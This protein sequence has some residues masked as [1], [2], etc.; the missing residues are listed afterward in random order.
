MSN[1]VQFNEADFQAQLQ[2]IRGGSL[3]CDLGALQMLGNDDNSDS[4]SGSELSRSLSPP[5][6]R[7]GRAVSVSSEPRGTANNFEREL[8]EAIQSLPDKTIG[9]ILTMLLN[10]VKQMTPSIKKEVKQDIAKCKTSLKKVEERLQQVSEQQQTVRSLH[11]ITGRTGAGFSLGLAQ[12][13]APT[14]GV[15]SRINRKDSSSVGSSSRS[16]KKMPRSQDPKGVEA[17][18]DSTRL[19]SWLRASRSMTRSH[20]SKAGFPRIS[21]TNSEGCEEERGDCAGAADEE[22]LNRAAMPWTKSITMPPT[23][24]HHAFVAEPAWIEDAS[25]T[26]GAVSNS[27]KSGSHPVS[28]GVAANPASPP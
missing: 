15:S 8:I 28:D 10:Y 16:A 12:R 24:Q 3:T 2:S 6:S 19:P 17:G 22:D 27:S 26:G 4:G 7:Q 9:N 21:E 20:G 23:L 13:T 25:S 18:I 14:D 5:P 11:K 1:Q